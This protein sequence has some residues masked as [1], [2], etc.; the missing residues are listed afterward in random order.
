MCCSRFRGRLPRRAAKEAVRLF[1]YMVCPRSELFERGLFHDVLPQDC[2]GWLSGAQSNEV[3]RMC[4]DGWLNLSGIPTGDFAL[5]RRQTKQYPGISEATGWMLY[6]LV[7]GALSRERIQNEG[8]A[9]GG[10]IVAGSCVLEK[11]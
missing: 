8:W 1:A 10:G 4:E 7:F 11:M 5:E 9:D 3:A 6:T 2:K